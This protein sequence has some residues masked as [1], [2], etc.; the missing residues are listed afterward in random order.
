MGQLGHP[1]KHTA[2]ILIQDFQPFRDNRG[3]FQK[4]FR[5]DH[6]EKLGYS[7]NFR[8]S[9]TS[10]SVPGVIR[11]MH[12]QAPP[13]HHWKLVSCIQGEILDICLDLHPGPNYGKTTRFSLSADNGHSLLI[14]PGF[15]HGF[16]SLGSLPSGVTYL[17]TSEH[18]PEYDAGIRWD[19]IGINWGIEVPVVSERDSKFPTFADF[20]SPFTGEAY[21]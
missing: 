8:E 21:K 15:A 16:L 18:D 4:V 14:P 12:F 3:T 11:G 6:L 20:K 13:A 17:T 1:M 5:Q 9:F 7:G 2:P 19:S 10:F